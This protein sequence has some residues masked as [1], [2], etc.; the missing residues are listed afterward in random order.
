[1]FKDWDQTAIRFI[2]DDRRSWRHIN[3][4]HFMSYARGSGIS[5]ESK[6]QLSPCLTDE[7]LRHED[8]W[9]SGCIDP[10]FLDLGSSWR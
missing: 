6:V 8:V 4:C 2:T 10:H 9:E 3:S 1:V 5:V 7:A